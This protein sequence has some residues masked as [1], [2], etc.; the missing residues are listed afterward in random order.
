M[1]TAAGRPGA[2]RCGPRR[3]PTPPRACRRAPRSAGTPRPPPGPRGTRCPRL[4]RHE[5][6]A[7]PRVV[8]V[9]AVQRTGSIVAP[10]PA[11]PPVAPPGPAPAKA[12]TGCSARPRDHGQH[13]PRPGRAEPHGRRGRVRGR[14]DHRPHGVGHRQPD[15]VPARE[16]PRADVQFQR[17]PVGLGLAAGGGR[18]Q[19]PRGI[20]QRVGSPGP[21]APVDQRDRAVRRH[22]AEPG[23]PVQRR[24]VRRRR[25]SS[26]SGKPRISVSCRQRRGVEDQAVRVRAALVDGQLAPPV[27]GLDARP[28]ARSAAGRTG[29]PGAPPTEYRS[30]PQYQARPA[31]SGRRQ[32]VLAAA[33]ARQSPPGQDRAAASACTYTVTGGSR[34]DPVIDRP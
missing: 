22:V 20:A 26:T 11:R 16:H 6:E 8:A 33:S 32:R 15:P 10:V 2:P 29:R 1:A 24:R 14:P 7:T 34:H 4:P 23:E 21:A 28:T 3:A 30:G 31:W 18:G 25:A 9:P 13:Q 12:G 19:W 27:P 5:I 17:Q